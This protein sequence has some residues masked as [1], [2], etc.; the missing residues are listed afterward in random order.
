MKIPGDDGLLV[1]C[2]DQGRRK[3][4]GI[5][6]AVDGVEHDGIRTAHVIPRAIEIA[7]AVSVPNICGAL[8][9]AHG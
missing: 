1:Q 5:A 3:A 8:G 7:R 2:A 9:H 6:R 4:D